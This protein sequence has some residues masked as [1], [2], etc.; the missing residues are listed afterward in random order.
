MISSK[1]HMHIHD[2]SRLGCLCTL[3][4]GDHEVILFF[5]LWFPIQKK[6]YKH[7]DKKMP[8]VITGFH[9]DLD[10]NFKLP[11]QQFNTSSLASFET[12]IDGIISLIILLTAAKNK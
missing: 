1:S 9:R 4:N 8:G 2:L 5:F 7:I 3:D 12:R 6:K 10:K 11:V